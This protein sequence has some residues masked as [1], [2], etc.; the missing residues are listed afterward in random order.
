MSSERT[1]LLKL[2]IANNNLREKYLDAVVAHNNKLDNDLYPDSGFD[3]FLP[4]DTT[5]DFG[6]TKLVDL[7]VKCAAC[8][9]DSDNFV[10]NPTAFSVFARSSI[11]KHCLRLANN[12]GIIDSGYRGNL[13]AMVDCIRGL[14]KGLDTND[15]E[16]YSVERFSRLF[17]VCSPT[18]GKVRVIIVGSENDLGTSNRGDGGF[19]STGR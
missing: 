4:E 18:L 2:Y 5:F 6:T 16:T 14:G 15:M 9:L 13:M 7:G 8:W 11:G 12:V 3:L 1:M 19:G 10:S 17:Q